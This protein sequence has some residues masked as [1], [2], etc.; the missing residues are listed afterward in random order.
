MLSNVS[1]P[2]RS[3]AGLPE[4]G[5]AAGWRGWKP[6]GVFPF[7]PPKAKR[8]GSGGG[9]CPASRSGLSPRRPCGRQKVWVFSCWVWVFFIFVK[10]WLP[11]SGGNARWISGPETVTPSPSN[12]PSAPR[13]PLRAPAPGPSPS[14]PAL[15][16]RPLGIA[17]RHRGGQRRRKAG[18]V[19]GG[20]GVT[21]PATS[22]A[23]IGKSLNSNAI[24]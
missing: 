3:S 7:S 16:P 23:E 21:I 8:R 14:S 19:L 10:M 1:I 24:R 5:L 22:F 20:I 12:S 4:P 17:Y 18:P 9:C 6:P 13:F 2:A 11:S 15:Q